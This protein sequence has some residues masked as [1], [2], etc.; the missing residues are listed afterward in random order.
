[1]RKNI[2]LCCIFHFG[3]VTYRVILRLY[4]TLSYLTITPFIVQHFTLFFVCPVCCLVSLCLRRFRAAIFVLVVL[5]TPTLLSS[6]FW[7]RKKFRH[8]LMCTLL[9]LILGDFHFP[10]SVRLNGKV[11]IRVKMEFDLLSLAIFIWLLLSY[12]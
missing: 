10:S 11:V 4:N 9:R 3:N 2:E 1:M 8:I 12:I 6:V 5:A 7:C